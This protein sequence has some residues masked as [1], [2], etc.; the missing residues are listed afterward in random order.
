MSIPGILLGAYM[1]FVFVYFFW[2]WNRRI[3]DHERMLSERRRE[4]INKYGEE[5][6]RENP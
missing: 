1:V 5:A 2:Q 3:T 6:H 4:I